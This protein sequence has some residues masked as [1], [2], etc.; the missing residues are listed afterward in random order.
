MVKQEKLA[1]GTPEDIAD[2]QRNLECVNE[3]MY[4]R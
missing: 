3:E 1:A 4:T 2:D